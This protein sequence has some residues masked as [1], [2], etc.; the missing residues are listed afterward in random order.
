MSTEELGAFLDN[1]SALVS[2]NKETEAQ[3]YLTHHVERLPEDLK[4]EI[5]GLMFFEAIVDEAR[6][7]E[8]ITNIQKEGLSAIK[9]LESLKKEMLKGK[10]ETTST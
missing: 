3:E 9:A 1:M 7:V 4:N 10:K 6:G 5:L 2:E 8:V